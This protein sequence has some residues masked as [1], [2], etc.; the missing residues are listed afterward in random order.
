MEINFLAEK[1][2]QESIMNVI[3]EHALK[4]Q[5]SEYDR[6]VCILAISKARELILSIPATLTPEQYRSE[7]IEQLSNFQQNYHDS[8][9]QYTSGKGVI[10]SLLA[11]LSIALKP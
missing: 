2:M 9:G 7:L 1:K 3:K 6:S 4:A 11:D 10:G 8:E 5:D